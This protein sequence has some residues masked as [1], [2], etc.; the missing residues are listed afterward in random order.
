MPPDGKTISIQRT[1]FKIAELPEFFLF[2]TASWNFRNLHIRE[3][4]FCLS[5]YNHMF[6]KLN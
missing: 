5:F 3:A 6:R 4:P 1:I 2:S